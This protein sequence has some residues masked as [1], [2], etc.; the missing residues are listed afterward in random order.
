MTKFTNTKARQKAI[1]N[2]SKEW[3]KAKQKIAYRKK[4][5][6]YDFSHKLPIQN[7]KEINNLSTN[8]IKKLTKSIHKDFNTKYPQAFKTMEFDNVTVRT[9]IVKQMRQAE[10]KAK[11]LRQQ[12]QEEIENLPVMLITEDGITPSDITVGQQQ[13]YMAK[14]DFSIY[15][16]TNEYD[17]TKATSLENI[18]KALESRQ[19]KA[20]P[21]YINW[22]RSIMK[23]NFINSIID[24]FND[25]ADETV[26][27]LLKLESR[28]FY[29]LSKMFPDLIN[30]AF[31]DSDQERP[32]DDMYDRLEDLKSVVDDYLNGDFD[33]YGKEF[34]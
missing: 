28:D 33:L 4:T 27:L 25:E 12:A 32:S 7:K 26:N 6:D 21:D 5:L 1:E 24:I 14:P 31:F 23:D 18:Q 29:I 13:G 16:R 11:E 17:F 3:K 19:K 15:G 22:R 10:R 20:D 30:F 8:E 2:F 9:S 34:I